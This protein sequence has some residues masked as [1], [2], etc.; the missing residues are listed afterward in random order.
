MTVIDT[1]LEVHRTL[2]AAD[3][4]HAFGGAIALAFVVDPRGTADVDVNVFVTPDDL[5]DALAPLLDIGF[6]RPAGEWKPIAGLRLSRSGDPVP[7]DVFPSI[8]DRYAEVHA[9]IQWYPFGP[10]EEDIPVLSA[11]DLA[12]FKLSFGRPKDWVDL[13]AMV[14]ARPDLDIDLIE[15]LLTSLR[16]STMYPRIARL[17]SMAKR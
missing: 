13:Q 9:R 1:V 3:L 4:D 5:D 8:D 10:G 15:D 2:L 7:V 6:T 12:M 11:E 14:D 17:R 16:G